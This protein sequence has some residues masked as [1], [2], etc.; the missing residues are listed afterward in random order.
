MS[1]RMHTTMIAIASTLAL[2]PALAS[3]Q[4]TPRQE[5]HAQLKADQAALQG[6][7]AQL[8]SDTA[9]LRAGKAK[10]QMAAESRDTLRIHNDRQ[11]IRSKTKDLAADTARPQRR[12]ADRAELTA[13]Q[14][15]LKTDQRQRHFDKLHGRMAA[16]SP[17]AEK[18]YR[19]QQ[20]IRG[21]EKAIASDQA[22]LRATRSAQ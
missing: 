16:T 10:G 4:V 20:A 12:Q 18:V 5:D 13:D 9:T 21:Q 19:D 17:D 2:M 7:R 15:K 1:I 22:S 6:E 14:A 3:A 8:K 11:D